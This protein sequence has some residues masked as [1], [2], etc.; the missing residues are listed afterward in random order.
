MMI[1]NPYLFAQQTPLLLDTYPTT[2]VAYSLRKLKN[3][4]SGS[5]IRIRR[6]NDNAETD[7]GFVNGNL[8][9]TTMSGFVGNNDAFVTTWYDQSGSGLNATQTT[10]AGQP[11]IMLSGV[12]ETNANGKPGIRFIDVSNVLAFPVLIVP[13]WHANTDTWVGSF[14]TYQMKTNGFYAYIQG[15]NNE[16]RGYLILH[17]T[18]TRQVRTFVLRTSGYFGANGAALNIN[19]LY[20][21]YDLANRTNVQTYLNGSTTP[22]VNAP[23]AN[24]NFSMPTVSYRLGNP[25]NNSPGID[26]YISEFIAYKTNQSS[27]AAA[28][29]TNIKTY[30]SIP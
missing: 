28:I 29:Q 25:L 3:S 5:A 4:Y 26:A 17:E 23:D 24:V 8:D 14:T 13:L 16:D 12:T 30:Y 11:R 2:G 18:T 10:A 15:S 19:Q 9:T 27:N 6:S 1:I 20:L 22:T 21:R 7:I